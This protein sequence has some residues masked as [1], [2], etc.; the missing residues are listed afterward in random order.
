MKLSTLALTL[1]SAVF[2][3][4]AHAAAY[5]AGSFPIDGS[6]TKVGF[7]IPHMV[8]SSVDGTFSEVEGNVTLADKFEK[9]SVKASVDVKSINT[10]NGKRDDHLR[11]PDF[12]DVAKHPKMTFESTA[13]KGTQ[14]SFKLEGK[15]TIHGVTK[16]VTFE[17]K[18]LG[19]V[20]DGFGNERVAFTA[21][22]KVNRKDFGLTWNKAIEAGPVV[23][24]ELTI[25]LKVEAARPLKK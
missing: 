11:S 10:G 17:G 24:D 1:S 15:L 8:I 23:G 13:I 3:L 9:S 20:N 12:F 7:E 18:Y 6:H 14:E 19:L 2:A 5:K 4:S 16:P 22:T 25:N 21:T